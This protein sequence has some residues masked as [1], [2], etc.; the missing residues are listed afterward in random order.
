M[1]RVRKGIGAL[2]KQLWETEPVLASQLPG[3]SRVRLGLED[4]G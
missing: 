2:R 3:G 1:F 4:M